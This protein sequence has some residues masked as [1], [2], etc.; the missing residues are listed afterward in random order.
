MFGRNEDKSLL[1]IEAE[2][3]SIER[4]CKLVG[5]ASMDQLQR[6]EKLYYQQTLKRTQKD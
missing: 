3:S 2:I 6:L 5:R 1:E 4:V